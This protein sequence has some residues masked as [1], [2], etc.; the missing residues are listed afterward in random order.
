[1]AVLNQ[2][3]SGNRLLHDVL[4]PNCLARFDR[5]VLSQPGVT[6]VIVYEGINDIGLPSYLSRP[7][8][9]V[10]SEDII[11]ALRQLIERAHDKGLKI[12]G[13]TMTPFE[14]TD[15]PYYS[16]AGE[17]KRE[18]VNDWIRS[19]A[20]FDAVIDFD[21]V[22]RDPAHPRRLLPAYDSGDHLHPGDAGYAAMAASID[23]ALL[24]GP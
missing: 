20:R 23:P 24:V 7:A 14:G 1:M 10:S 8:E 13:A 3:I 18:A 5:D 2:G 9:D 22:V 21:R 6:H 16:V 4:G 11:G 17:A 15:A 19:H 12:Y